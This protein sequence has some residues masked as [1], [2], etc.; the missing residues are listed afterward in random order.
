MGDGFSIV[1][2]VYLSP[3]D[4]LC[5]VEAKSSSPRQEK[6]PDRF[7]EWVS[8]I[9]TKF[10]DS[11]QLFL[12]VFLKRRE[13][14]KLGADIESADMQIMPIKFVLVIPNH[15]LD[16]LAPI[17]NELKKQLNKT[18]TMW[19]ISVAVMNEELAKEYGMIA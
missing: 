6:D 8:E 5:F 12:T 18:T 2:F 17:Q 9:T 1:E 7:E 13:E 19:N 3:K 15:K 10:N 11:F 16:W 14:P 4:Q